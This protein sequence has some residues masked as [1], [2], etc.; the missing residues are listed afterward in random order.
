MK[1]L[2]Y[3]VG[4]L[5]IILF[6][7]F[8]K[9][10]DFPIREI[11]LYSAKVTFCVAIAIQMCIICVWIFFYKRNF[12]MC[13]RHY[14]RYNDGSV[15]TIKISSLQFGKLKN[16]KNCYLCPLNWSKF[17][18]TCNLNMFITEMLSNAITKYWY[19]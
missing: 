12:Q 9:V 15:L 8:F 18:N 19:L 16:S 14:G 11:M 2:Q 5:K 6:F 13:G 10:S 17:R 3:L 1:W 4:F 7:F